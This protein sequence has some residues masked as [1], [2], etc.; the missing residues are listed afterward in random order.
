M[1]LEGVMSKSVKLS[2]DYRELDNYVYVSGVND[3]PL[4]ISDIGKV[5][6]HAETGLGHHGKFR[7]NDLLEHYSD[8]QVRLKKT[9]VP[10]NPHLLEIFP[11]ETRFEL[12]YIEDSKK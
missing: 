1:D 12:K 6:T 4:R 11:K 8:S 10:Y 2:K 5:D 3:G 7:L 9:N